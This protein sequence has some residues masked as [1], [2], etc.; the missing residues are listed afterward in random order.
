[1]RNLEMAQLLLAGGA[2]VTIRDDLGRNAAGRVP[3]G[4]NPDMDKLRAV[5]AGDGLGGEIDRAAPRE[6]VPLFRATRDPG[7]LQ[8][9]Q[10]LR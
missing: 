2:D 5:C 4:G 10:Q 1:M 8:H 6:P 9:D 7:R 3:D